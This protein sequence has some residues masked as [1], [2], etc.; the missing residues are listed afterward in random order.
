[1]GQDF[2]PAF[3]LSYV[4]QDFSPAFPLSY[5]GQDFSPAFPLSYVGQDFSPASSV[6]PLRP[7]SRRASARAAA[8]LSA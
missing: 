6:Y 5:V 3:P 7:I 8:A 2:S 1:M 4:G